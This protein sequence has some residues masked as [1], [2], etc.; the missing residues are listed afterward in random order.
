M[1]ITNEGEVPATALKVTL[2]TEPRLDLTSFSNSKTQTTEDG[3]DLQPGETAVL[4]LTVTTG[5]DDVLGE[6]RG[7]VAL[8][9]DLAS[10]S[11]NYIFYV[12]SLD[13][14][15]VSVKVEDEFT[16]FAS[17]KPL[18]SGAVVTLRNPR[19]GYQEQRITTN[20][21]GEWM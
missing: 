5:S 21:T 19:R 11:I 7:S 14:L 6:F 2:P 1:N 20:K 13:K 8:N 4:I 10:A 18:V 12:T 9:S 16:Y 17:D 3:L 15:N